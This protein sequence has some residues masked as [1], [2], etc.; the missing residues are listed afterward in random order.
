VKILKVKI[1][2][3]DQRITHEVIGVGETESEAKN[4]ALRKAK[5]LLGTNKL[6]LK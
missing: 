5:K 6:E 4:N 2:D 1:K 3:L